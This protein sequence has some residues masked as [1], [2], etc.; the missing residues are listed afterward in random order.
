MLLCTKSAR[1]TLTTLYF[2]LNLFVTE[3]AGKRGGVVSVHACRVE[4]M[5]NAD[6]TA[7]TVIFPQHNINSLLVWG[8]GGQAG[9]HEGGSRPHTTTHSRSTWP[10]QGPVGQLQAV[11]THTHT[12]KHIHTHPSSSSHLFSITCFLTSVPTPRPSGGR[13]LPTSRL[14]TSGPRAR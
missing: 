13:S 6:D 3:G 5:H 2:I 11:L 12:H 8:D 1:N 4:T 10:W 14:V 9:A 7:R